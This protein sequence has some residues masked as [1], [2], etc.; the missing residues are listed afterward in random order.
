MR[1]NYKLTTRII[2]THM[3]VRHQKNK[4]ET[5][6]KLSTPKFNRNFFEFFVYNIQSIYYLKHNNIGT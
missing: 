5:D 3:R 1:S 6:T 4:N 2:Q